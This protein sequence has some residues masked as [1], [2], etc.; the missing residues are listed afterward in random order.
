[1]VNQ[2]VTLTN[3]SDTRLKIIVEPWAEEY[4]IEPNTKVL[5][6]PIG[7]VSTEIE[8]EYH[9]DRIII[10]GWFDSYSITSDGE[11]LKCDFT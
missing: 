10:H 5:I 9:S 11:P 3:E 7:K 8:I 6:T 2:I 4:Y 1:M